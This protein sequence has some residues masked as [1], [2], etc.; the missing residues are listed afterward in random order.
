MQAARNV[1]QDVRQYESVAYPSMQG[2]GATESGRLQEICTPV[3]SSS[4]PQIINSGRTYRSR[5]TVYAP[6][7]D[8]IF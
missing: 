1:G 5:Y 4:I 7:L 6:R 3:E 8:I 2:F